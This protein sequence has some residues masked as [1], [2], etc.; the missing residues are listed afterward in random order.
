MTTKRRLE[1]RGGLERDYRDVLTPAALAALDE[2]AP[3]N[4]DRIALMEA[5]IERRR[6]RAEAG[7]RIEFLNPDERIGRTDLTVRQAREGDFD[8]AEIPHDLERQWI[9]GTGPG[10]RPRAQVESSIRNV[11][12]ALLSGADGW[13]FDGE[14]ALGQLSTMSL[15]NQ[16]NLKLAIARDDLFLRV[17]EGVAGEMNAWAEGFFGRAIISDWREQLDFTTKIYRARGLHLDDRHVREADGTGFSASIVDAT[18]YV[19]NNAAALREAGSSMV[20]YLPKIQVAEEAALW[21][22]IL[23]GPRG[24][25]RSAGRDDQ[26]LRARRAGRGVVP[27]DGDP[28]RPRTALRWLQHRPMGLHQPASP[29][30]SPGTRASSTRTSTRSG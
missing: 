5:R 4:R 22:D 28:R 17:A 2:L 19:V 3:L 12:Y 20:L 11:A 15:D 21:N 9:Q 14:D 26:G 27:A 29:T 6:E 18:L 13:M 10:A 24:A 25:S 7:R 16:R 23:T 8:G 1:I 30:P